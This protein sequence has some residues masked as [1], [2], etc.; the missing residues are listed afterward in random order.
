[1]TKRDEAP[2]SLYQQQDEIK[3]IIDRGNWKNSWHLPKDSNGDVAWFSTETARKTVQLL[4]EAEES[5]IRLLVRVRNIDKRDALAQIATEEIDKL[6]AL[7]D[8]LAAMEALT[9]YLAETL[10]P[11]V[12]L[13]GELAMLDQARA[14][15]AKAKGD[16]P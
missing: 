9:E 5:A 12:A 16:A 13:P 10:G 11:N 3:A 8:L 2:L 6:E 14:A 1:M 4:C 15:I 7:P